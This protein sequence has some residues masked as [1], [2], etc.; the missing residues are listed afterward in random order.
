MKVSKIALLVALLWCGVSN[1]EGVCM[2]DFLRPVRTYVQLSRLSVRQVRAMRCRCCGRAGMDRSMVRLFCMLQ[3]AYGQRLVI[4]SGFRCAEHNRRV[5]G[6]VH[7]PHLKGRAVDVLMSASCQ[8]EFCALARGLGLQA[9]PD[10]RR[11]YVHLAL[12]RGSGGR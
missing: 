2:S 8:P 11:G 4:T 6:V 5:G 10:A 7:S 12:R 1:P 9:I 3:R